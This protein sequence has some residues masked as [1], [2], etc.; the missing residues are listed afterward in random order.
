M[1][2]S[3]VAEDSPANVKLPRLVFFTS[4]TSGACRR[5]EGLLANVLQHRRNYKRVKLVK[6][7]AQKRP[8]LLE[9]FRVERLPT[10]VVVDEKVAK[11][12]LECPRG[13]REI[14]ALLAPW[15]V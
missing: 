6:V 5:A 8:D 14:T 12:R 10:L 2:E 11:A 15:L 9:Q 7:D 1:G 4:S 3:R 13:T